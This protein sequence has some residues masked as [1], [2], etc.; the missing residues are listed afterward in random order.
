MFMFIWDL[1][2]SLEPNATFL[3]Y[4]SYSPYSKPEALFD[5]EPVVIMSF[6]SLGLHGGFLPISLERVNHNH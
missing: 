3:N 2:G 5:E 1:V 6:T 4:T